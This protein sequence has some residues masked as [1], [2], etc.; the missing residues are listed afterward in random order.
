MIDRNQIQMVE[1]AV[2]K[3]VKEF[4]HPDEIPMGALAKEGIDPSTAEQCEALL[5]SEDF[6]EDSMRAVAKWMRLIGEFSE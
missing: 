6:P 4:G 2:T 1:K 5:T 3:L